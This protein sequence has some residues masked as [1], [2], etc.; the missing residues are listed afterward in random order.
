MRNVDY[1]IVGQGLAGS[2]VACLLEMQRKRVL[3]IDNA[4]RTAASMAAAGIMNPITGK[5]LNR[6]FLV[7]QLLRVAFDIYPRIEQFLNAQFFQRRSVLRILKSEDESHQWKQRLASG[8]Y[9]KYLASTTVS[10]ADFIENRYGGF[11]IAEAGLLDV[12][13]FVRKVRDWLS[14]AKKLTESDFLHGELEF[15]GDNV[16]WRDY[17][18]KAIIFCE[19]YQLSRNPFFNSIALNPEKGEVLTLRA[20]NFRDERIVQHEKWLLRTLTGE[21]KAGTTYTWKEFDETPTRAAR[22]EIEVVKQSAGVRPVIKVDNRPIIGL[23]PLRRQ[24][25]V[26]N[27]LGSKGVLQAPFAARQLLAYLEA[28]EQIHPDFDVCRKSLWELPN[29][30]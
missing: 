9:A 4:H 14:F 12:P 18:A 24:V 23:H 16:R 7:D 17:I 6:P 1:M 2:L 10:G 26:M 28:R 19:G 25:A 3:V 5:R 11:E 8:K 13:L 29:N 22:A 30:A 21:I 15:T 27:G 20:G